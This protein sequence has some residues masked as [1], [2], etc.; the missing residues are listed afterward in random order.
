MLLD[1]VADERAEC[2]EDSER[3]RFL[4]DLHAELRTLAPQFPEV[5][6]S[7]VIQRLRG[8]CEAVAPGFAGDTVMA[9]LRDCIDE[10][11]RVEAEE[12]P[13]SRGR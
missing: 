12:G 3:H 5:P 4:S 1:L 6:A 2:R 10:L 9:H 8:I 13:G 7:V 11:E